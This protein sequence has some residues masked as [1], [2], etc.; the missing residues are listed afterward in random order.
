MK[1]I[2]ADLSLDMAMLSGEPEQAL[3]SAVMVRM[4]GVTG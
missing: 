4:S 3:P 1:K 2:V